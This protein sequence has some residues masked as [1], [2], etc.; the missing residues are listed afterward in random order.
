[1]PYY[2]ALMIKDIIESIYIFTHQIIDKILWNLGPLACNYSFSNL[3]L[4]LVRC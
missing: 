4:A 3:L 1:M 2:F